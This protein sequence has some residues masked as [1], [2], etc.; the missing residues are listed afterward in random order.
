MLRKRSKSKKGFFSLAAD[1][2]SDKFSFD[3]GMNSSV[4]GIIPN[5]QI[6]VIHVEEPLIISA[7]Y[8]DI[9]MIYANKYFRSPNFMSLRYKA[10]LRIGSP[11]P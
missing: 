11:H 3:L 9:G 8:A 7:T 5:A 2:A 6:G 4:R 1:S 10:I